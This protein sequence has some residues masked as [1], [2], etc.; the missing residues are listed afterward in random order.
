MIP[1]VLDFIQFDAGT[2]VLF[3]GN[4]T[5]VARR[6]VLRT[7]NKRPRRFQTLSGTEARPNTQQPASHH[8]YGQRPRLLSLYSEPSTLNLGMQSVSIH[9][10]SYTCGTIFD[11]PFLPIC[12]ACWPCSHSRCRDSSNE[13]QD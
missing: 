7:Q 12:T 3:R 2:V 5:P 9:M 4:Q 1:I 8:N 10:D 13:H 6:Q 11:N